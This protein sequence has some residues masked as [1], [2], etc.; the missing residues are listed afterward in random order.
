LGW[1]RLKMSPQMTEI[2]Q[3]VWFELCGGD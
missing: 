2:S 3:I 1:W